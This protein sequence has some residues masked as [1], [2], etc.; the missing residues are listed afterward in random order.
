[1]PEGDGPA[2][3]VQPVER[4]PELLCDRDAGCGIRLVVLDEVEILH[5]ETR[6]LQ[7]LA[8]R[9]NRRLHHPLRL[10]A[11]RRVVHDPGKGPHAVLLRGLVRHDDECGR[12][13]TELARVPRSDEPAL[14]EDGRELRKLVEGRVRADSLVRVER[15]VARHVDGSHERIPLE[16]GHG[17]RRKVLQ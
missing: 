11:A 1:M 3:D 6:L 9:W 14:L 4:N 5:G 7:E 13:V 8:H 10:R 16:D 2:M 12:A 17:S 15:T